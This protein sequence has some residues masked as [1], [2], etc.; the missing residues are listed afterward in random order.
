MTLQKDSSELQVNAAEPITLTC[1][2]S[3]GV[4]DYQYYWTS[5]C[6][7][8]CFVKWQTAQSVSRNA[9]RSIDSGLHTCTATDSVGNTGSVN[10]LIR[11]QSKIQNEIICNLKKLI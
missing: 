1:E 6:T 8:E 10:I 7:G 4:G 3:G 11:V 9:A 2:A 5:N